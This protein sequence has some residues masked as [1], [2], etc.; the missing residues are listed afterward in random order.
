MRPAKQG[1]LDGLCGVYAI[2]NALRR[3]SS[4]RVPP[5]I[6]R[7]AFRHL[8]KSIPKA[9]MHAA[10]TD[11][12]DVDEC[13][14]IG[15]RA[16]RKLRRDHSLDIRISRPWAGCA[17]LTLDRYLGAL[18]R[19]DRQDG[20]AAIIRFSKPGYTHWTV[21]GRPY[22]TVLSVEDSWTIK[23][24]DLSRFRVGAGPHRFWPEDTLV[25]GSKSPLTADF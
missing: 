17:D 3:A 18:E 7:E 22:P 25:V 20:T 4:N 14:H 19:I 10:L 2:I 21:A 23:S 13:L 24:L 16:F 9:D 8:I 15:R 6:C 11:G 12:L 1:T 5:A